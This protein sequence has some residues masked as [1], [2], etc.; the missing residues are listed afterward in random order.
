M[1]ERMAFVPPDMMVWLANRDLTMIRKTRSNGRG[2]YMSVFFVVEEN[3]GALVSHG[4]S[5]DEA[6][7]AAV[8]NAADLD[9]LG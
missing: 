2:H 6:F 1:Q 8:Q 5:V 9:G 4:D 7:Q 3:T